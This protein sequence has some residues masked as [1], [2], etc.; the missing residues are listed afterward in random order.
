MI[1]SYQKEAL[2]NR[3]RALLLHFARNTNNG[4]LYKHAVA[5]LPGDFVC[6]FCLIYL[7]VLVFSVKGGALAEARKNASNP[8]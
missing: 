4:E 3:F 8:L 7:T 5:E 6:L 2:L 1:P